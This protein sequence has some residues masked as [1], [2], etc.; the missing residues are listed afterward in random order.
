MCARVRDFA[1]RGKADLPVGG[2]RR[3]VRHKAA[4]MSQDDPRPTLV[5]PAV[6]ERGVWLNTIAL[7][8]VFGACCG[9]GL[10]LLTYLS[11]AVTGEEAGQY[12]NLL[13]VFLPGYEVS[14]T[15]AWIGFF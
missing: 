13:G 7:A 12:L 3:Q 8:I 4:S 9:L 2:L 11:I 5:D 6:L 10:L 14:A 1:S 15:G